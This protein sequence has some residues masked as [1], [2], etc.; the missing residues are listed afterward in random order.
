MKCR[1]RIAP[2][3]GRDLDEQTAF[4]ASGNVAAGARFYANVNRACGYLGR[5]PEMG[6]RIRGAAQKLRGIRVVPVPGFRRYLIVYRIEDDA[7]IVVRILHSA[8]DIPPMLS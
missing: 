6:A 1:V 4:I 2:A 7:I 5:W 8:R 3:A